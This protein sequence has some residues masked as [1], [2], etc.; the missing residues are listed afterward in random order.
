[1]RWGWLRLAGG[2]PAWGGVGARLPPLP[3]PRPARLHHKRGGAAEAGAAGGAVDQDLPGQRAAPGQPARQRVEEAG[4]ARPCAQVQR[5]RRRVA[6]TPGRAA[7]HELRHVHASLS[8][9][10]CGPHDRKQVPG[11]GMAADARQHGLL[12]LPAPPPRR[13]AVAQRP[14]LQRHRLDAHQVAVPA[15]IR[16]ARQQAG[17]VPGEGGT[18]GGLVGDGRRR[19]RRRGG[20]T[21]TMVSAW[22]PLPTHALG[23]ARF[24]AA[25]QLLRALLTLAAGRCLGAGGCL[26]GCLHGSAPPPVADRQA[27][28]CLWQG[29][30]RQTI[31]LLGRR[32]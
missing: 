6:V 7:L 30:S 14:P 32:D 28:L 20:N 12:P 1:M 29:A 8:A 17:W 9:P 25:V 15:L 31:L 16:Q 21:S 26:L 11:R 13:H 18:G 27:A 10:T 24:A 5:E 3:C 2:S 19:W 23:T 22:Q 4:F